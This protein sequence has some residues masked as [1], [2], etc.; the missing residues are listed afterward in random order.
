MRTIW[1][2]AIIIAV[3]GTFIFFKLKKKDKGKKFVDQVKTYGSL[4]EQRKIFQIINEHRAEVG[5]PTIFGSAKATE[6][7][8]KRA[9]E[10]YDEDIATGAISHSGAGRTFSHLIASGADAVGECLAKG[11]VKPETVCK[12]W[13]ASPGHNRIILGSN[14][15]WIGIG[16]YKTE[17]HVYRALIFIAD[18]ET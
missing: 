4:G 17:R 2:I 3:V 11:Y 16:V 7:A 15:D 1:I 5:L 9:K 13:F 14:W 6:A 18:D 10:I 12:R 8:Q